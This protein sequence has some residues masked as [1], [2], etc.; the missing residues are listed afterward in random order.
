MRLADLFRRQPFKRVFCKREFANRERRHGTCC[1][2]LVRVELDHATYED[3]RR[4]LELLKVCVVVSGGEVES[5]T[6]IVGFTTFK[7]R[8]T[9]YRPRVL[10]VR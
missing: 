8:V 7:G 4:L 3:K 6:G 10:F 2:S 5:M 1:R 9:P